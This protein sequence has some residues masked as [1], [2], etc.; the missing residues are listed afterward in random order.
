FK[1]NAALLKKNI[2]SRPSQ[3]PQQQ[4]RK[5]IK[6]DERQQ[7]GQQG[8]SS[9]QNLQQ[10]L[11]KC[12]DLRGRIVRKLSIQQ[13]AMFMDL[14]KQSVAGTLQQGVQNLQQQQAMALLMNTINASGIGSS[15]S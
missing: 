5:R 11:Q 14:L 15:S 12:F 10:L 2:E 6:K 7:G 4:E 3:R 8:A 9:A 13:K 1:R